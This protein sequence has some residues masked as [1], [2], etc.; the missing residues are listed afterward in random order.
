VGACCV[1]MWCRAA[2][3]E[4]RARVLA[5][6]CAAACGALTAA[7][8][9]C[10]CARIGHRSDVMK[11][12]AQYSATSGASFLYGLSTREYKNPQFDFLKQTNP[13]FPYFMSLVKQYTLAIKPSPALK[14]LLGNIAKDRTV[15]LERAVHRSEFERSQEEK[16]RAQ[17]GQADA[18][19]VLFCARG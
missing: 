13:L 14:Q 2:L 1:R 15:V 3:A 18:V 4:V 9:V 16:K 7:C 17:V 12:T 6:G 8:A 11:L 10:V 19:C 5:R